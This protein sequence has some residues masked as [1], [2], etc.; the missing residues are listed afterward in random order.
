MGGILVPSCIQYCQKTT[1]RDCTGLLRHLEHCYWSLLCL[2][3][4]TFTLINNPPASPTLLLT[5]PMPQT[6][7]IAPAYNRAVG[8]PSIQHSQAFENTCF[9]YL[10]GGGR[11]YLIFLGRASGFFLRFF[12]KLTFDYAIDS[13]FSLLWAFFT[14]P[15]TKVR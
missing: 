4:F 10:S 7:S 9:S 14:T 13:F 6:Y 8:P 11:P 3:A 2:L 15:A 5:S 1:E 12:R